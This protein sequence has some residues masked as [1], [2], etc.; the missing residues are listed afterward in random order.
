MG[1]L[2]TVLIIIV[3]VLLA[4]V[5]LIQNS[6]GGGLSS[7]L[8]ASNQVM[9]VRRTTDFLEKATYGLAIALLI[10]SLSS[11]FVTTGNKVVEEKQSE[12]LDKVNDAPVNLP[13]GIQTTPA[14][15]GSQ[16]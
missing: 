8:S 16:E 12:I 1:T 7:G 9:G 3:C 13:A 14:E 4:T 15:E 6:K 5:I 2:I 10:L 11:S